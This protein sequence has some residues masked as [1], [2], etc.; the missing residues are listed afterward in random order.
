MKPG[1]ESIPDLRHARRVLLVKLSSLGDVIR[2][3]PCLRAVRRHLA[4]AEIVMVVDRALADVVRHDPAVDTLIESP[5]A[6]RNRVSAMLAA[7]RGLAPHR[8][9]AF[10][11]AIDFQGTPRSAAWTYAS[12]ARLMAGRG[13][14]RPG[15]HFC[16]MA[17]LRRPDTLDSLAILERLGIPIEDADPRIVLD[18]N[19]E[20]S[21][22][23]WLAARGLP[24]SGF[25]AINPFSRWSSKEWP[26][27]R[28]AD[29]VHRLRDRFRI[30]LVVTGGPAEVRAA[31]AFMGRLKPGSAVSLAG[32]LGLARAFCV[33]ARA[34]VMITGDTGPMHAAA[35]LKVPV[36]A[37]FGPTWPE[38]AG[39]WGQGHCVIQ[40]SR[41]PDYHAYRSPGARAHMLAIDVDTVYEAVVKI[42]ER[43]GQ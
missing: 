24:P 10:D 31:E 28:Y 43:R 42:L 32:H 12:R 27:E 11:V 17:D 18:P 36:V 39:P 25:I 2:V 4:D 15:W 21:T 19:V 30:P 14:W 7:V 35:A 41:A 1:R 13:S 22:S 3:T 33:Y 8:G 40:R 16:V 9:S 5:G 38:R 34:A 29:L 37:L 6:S 23:A 20:A 26:A